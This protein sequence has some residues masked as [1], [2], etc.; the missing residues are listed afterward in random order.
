MG[1]TFACI[2]GS[3]FKALKFGDRFWYEN[4]FPDTGFTQSKLFFFLKTTPRQNNKN[5]Q[6]INK[7]YT[8]CVI[9]IKPS[10]IFDSIKELIIV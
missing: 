4:D 3:Q 1:P 6:Q 7:E 8:L 2:V 5:E 10:F 9:L